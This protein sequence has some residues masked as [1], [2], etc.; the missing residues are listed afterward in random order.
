[1]KILHINSY[2]NGGFFYKNLYD[3][4]VKSGLDIKVYVPVPKN[5]ALLSSEFGEYSLIS[6]SF[7]HAERYFFHLKSAHIFKD[8]DSRLS[9]SDYDLVHA[10]TLFTNGYIAYKLK[11]KYG[12]PYVVTVRNTDINTFFKKMKHLRYLGVRIM[13]EA[14]HITFLSPS[15]QQHTLKTYVPEPKRAAIR[16]KSTVIGNGLDPYWSD[17]TAEQKT[18]TSEE[19]LHL[20]QVGN[21]SRNKN[22]GATLDVIDLMKKDGINVH[23]HAVGKV[24]DE[25]LLNRIINHTDATYYSYMDKENLLKLYKK[26]HIFVLPSHQESFGNVYPEALSQGLPVIYTL[27]QGFHHQFDEGEVGYGVDSNS[28][29]DI[30]NKIELILNGYNEFS[31]NALNGAEKFDW[32][33]I[34]EL[35]QEVYT[36]SDSN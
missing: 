18:Y 16:A 7:F 17:H 11:K 35:Y 34:S 22:I 20:L 25:E 30:K 36:T 27:H 13:E 9:V 12:I 32:R 26:C 29:E 31:S 10:H 14:S 21:I 15:Y 33:R 23:L 3:E 2:Y 19:T 4:Q 1:M 28:P 8:I 5:R 6:P 24:K